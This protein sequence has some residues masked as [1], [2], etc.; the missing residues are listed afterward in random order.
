MHYSRVLRAEKGTADPSKYQCVD[1]IEKITSNIEVGFCWE[2]KR[3]R[4]NRGYGVTG[5]GGKKWYVH[6]GL[7]GR[8]WSGLSRPG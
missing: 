4:N 8:S 5:F 3:K 7:C 6:T 2:W 1:P